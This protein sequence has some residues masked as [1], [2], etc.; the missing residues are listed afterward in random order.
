MIYL[1]GTDFSHLTTDELIK[2]I[3]A[4]KLPDYIRSKAYGIDVRE[5]LAQMTEMTIQL[6]VNMGLSP[7]DALK[8]ARKLQESVSQSE[9]D[10]WVATLLDGGPSIFMNTLSELQATYPN[11][12]AG[13]ALVR[14]TDPARIYVWNG[15]AWEDFGAYQGIEVKDGTV[16]IEKTDF[17]ERNKNLFS[18][19]FVMNLGVGGGAGT[20]TINNLAGRTSALIPVKPNTTYTVTASELGGNHFGVGKLTKNPQAGNIVN[21]YFLNPNPRK[22]TLTTNNEEIYII[23]M[24]STDG[25][26]PNWLQVEEGNKATEFE[27]YNTIKANIKIHEDN[28][29]AG[30]VITE[31]IAEKAITPD[32]TDF[33]EFSTFNR[34]EYETILASNL[35]DVTNDGSMWDKGKIISSQFTSSLTALNIVDVT[36]HTVYNFPYRNVNFLR[37]G[38]YLSSIDNSGVIRRDFTIPPDANEMAI[39][40][41]IADVDK[42]NIIRVSPFGNERKITIPRLDMTSTHRF[43]GQKFLHF[44]DSI[45]S[46]S[47]YENGIAD[48]VS[49]RLGNEF[50][51][52]AIGGSKMSYGE[53]SNSTPMSASALARAH[54][55]ND[56]TLQDERLATYTGGLYDDAF[57]SLDILK[58][59]NL[60]NY[61]IATVQLGT[62]DFLQQFP[63]GELDKDVNTFKG[64]YS[65]FIEELSTLYPNLKFILVS[66]PFTINRV[67]TIPLKEYVNAV[68]D[69]ANYYNLPFIDNYSNAGIN[70]FNESH[71]FATDKIHPME[72]TG[73]KLLGDR[74]ASAIEN[75]Y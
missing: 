73:I 44:G 18:G 17:V 23:V 66:P 39:T 72:S 45:T 5:T 28:L 70:D 68:E 13:V 21:N 63:I 62:N 38:V 64:A 55:T 74:I 11:G 46:N 25:S 14:E 33:V 40:A 1:A 4:L 3:K 34:Q 30:S 31:K 65:Y 54:V 7:D 57:H 29:T 42:E 9:F 53:A 20:Y 48:I 43:E 35:H 27:P 15:T 69:V 51:N 52:L 26:R 71:Y 19:N 58:N 6:G 8:W 2:G 41:L 37:D 32:K 61:T 56:F 16:S 49:Q 59:G 24:V 67:D 47:R 75:N 10:S 50:D 60:K 12:A 36:P 22:V